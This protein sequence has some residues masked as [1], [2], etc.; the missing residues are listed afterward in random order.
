MDYKTNQ[1]SSNAYANLQIWV[2]NS[3]VLKSD[4]VQIRRGDIIMEIYSV[5]PLLSEEQK[6]SH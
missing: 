1:T 2:L 3:G 4:M 6:R 5:L